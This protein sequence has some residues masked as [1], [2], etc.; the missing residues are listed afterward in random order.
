MSTVFVSAAAV[1]VIG[2][3]AVLMMKEVPLRTQ[4][5][6]EAQRAAER[7]SPL[8]TQAA[9]AVPVVVPAEAADVRRDGP[10]GP[11]SS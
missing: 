8:E 3:F 2:L 7:P 9:S 1:L 11:E 10:R 4:S 6:V 5:G